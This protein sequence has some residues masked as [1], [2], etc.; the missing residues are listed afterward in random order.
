VLQ[1][2]KEETSKG[3]E[4]WEKKGGWFKHTYI[5][6]QLDIAL[7]KQVKYIHTC[8]VRSYSGVSGVYYGQADAN[9]KPHG[10]GVAY[11][12]GFLYEGWF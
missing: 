9:G 3:Y 1:L 8:K 5:P 11:L 12:F 2:F 6:P 10:W 4:G 7:V